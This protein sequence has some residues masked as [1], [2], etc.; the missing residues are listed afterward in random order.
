MIISASRRTDIPAFY[1]KWFMHR[2]KEGYFIKVNPFNPKQKKVVSLKREDVDC[3]VFWTKNPQPFMKHLDDLDRCGYHYYFQFTLNDYPEQF[4]P[5]LPSLQTRINIFKQL[6]E[7]IGASR[8]VWRFDPIIFSSLTDESYIK[9]KFAY[10]AEQLNGFTERV[11]ISFVDMYGKTKNKFKKLENENNVEFYSLNF[12]RIHSFAKDLS[13]IAEQHHLNIYSC[14]EKLDLQSAG[15]LHGACIDRHFIEELFHLQLNTK[16]DPNQRKECLCSIS[17]EMG[18]YDTCRFQ[19]TYCYAVRSEKTV[20]KN[21]VKHHWQ[22]PMLIGDLDDKE[23]LF[24][25]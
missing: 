25:L 24:E 19:C 8:V 14:S 15:I 12:D 23:Q 10:I 17:E 18:A 4:E 6:S 13:K 20:Q 7:R 5:R 9:E 2:M 11:V 1:S 22:N 21:I 3:I 16:K